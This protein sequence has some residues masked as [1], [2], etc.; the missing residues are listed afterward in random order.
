MKKFFLFPLI[1]G[2]LLTTLTSC[3][4]KE[5]NS[6]TNSDILISEYIESSSSSRAIELYNKSS[7][8]VS[9]K[10]YS[11]AIYFKGETTPKYEIELQGNIDKESTF[12]IA[13]QESIEEIKNKANLISDK[14][15]FNGTQQVALRK[16]GKIIDVLGDIG[17]TFAYG[18][19]ITLVRKNFRMNSTNKF[20][21]YDWIRYNVDNFSY[22]G[23]VENSV[24]ESELNIGPLIDPIYYEKPF[25][26]P[27]REN[28]TCGGVIEVSLYAGVDGDTAKFYYPSHTGIPN[29]TKVRFENINTPESY[30]A[31]VQ[32]WGIPAKFWTTEQLKNAEKIELQ[33]LDGG[34]LY[35]TFD[36]VLAWVWVDGRLLNYDIVRNGFSE[37]A[38]S[39]VD[40]M[41]YK[42]ISLT[43]WLYDAQLKAKREGKG[44][45]GEKDPYWD[46]ENNKLKEEY[47][48][49]PNA[50]PKKE[51]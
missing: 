14:L 40:N 8:S 10:D 24:T 12:V 5:N 30:A 25:I 26:D 23:N 41:F 44:I 50:K 2:I 3:S 29:G 35:D 18:Q 7:E 11:L 33:T 15:M 20:D 37:I 42:D 17:T 48:N 27:E 39:S 46:Y 45:W 9:L 22:L 31:N 32:P 28:I 43:N 16:K 51:A 6:L 36:R 47:S 13:Y 19:D 4:K 21:E 34:T 49:L 38:F 1:G